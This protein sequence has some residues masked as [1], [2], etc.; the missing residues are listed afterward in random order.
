MLFGPK[1]KTFKDKLAMYE[2][3]KQEIIYRYAGDIVNFSFLKDIEKD[4]MKL[5]KKYNK[6]TIKSI[7]DVIIESTNTHAGVDIVIERIKDE[8]HITVSGIVDYIYESDADPF[9]PES[10]KKCLTAFKEQG[11]NR[12]Y[13]LVKMDYSTTIPVAIFDIQSLINELNKVKEELT[14]KEYEAFE[15]CVQEVESANPELAKRIRVPPPPIPKP[16]IKIVKD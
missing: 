8:Y 5:L 7:G 15:R 4:L 3:N 11:I 9:V 14:K 6:V 1:R 12:Y 16:K 10:H 2:I 13:R